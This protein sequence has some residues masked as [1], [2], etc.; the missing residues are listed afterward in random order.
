[1]LEEILEKIKE[2]YSRLLRDNLVGIYVHGS[3]AFHCFN[4]KKS[5]IDFI[6]VIKEKIDNQTKDALIKVLLDMR[7][8]AP[9]KGFEMSVVLQEYCLHFEYPTPY[10]LHFSNGWL[11][12]YFE[13]SSSVCNE[14]L[15]TDIDLAAHFAVIR[16]CGVVLYGEPIAEVFGDIKN[17][18][19]ADSIL[20]DIAGAKERIVQRPTYI[21]LNLC[22]ALA[23]FEEGKLL[24]KEQGGLWA[25]EWVKEEYQAVIQSA[26]N[27]YKSETPIPVRDSDKMEFAE[28]MLNHIALTRE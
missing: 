28:D 21:T 8:S 27:D 11:D 19:I 16:Q 13:D 22:R 9:P 7:G 3:I 18:Y 23:F 17:K 20:E 10:E 14:D 25:S 4:P 6:V 2:E 12:R 15:K 1:M 26:L 24:S 5:D